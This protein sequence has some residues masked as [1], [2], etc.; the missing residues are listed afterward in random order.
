MNF[1]IDIYSFVLYMIIFGYFGTWVGGFMEY[2]RDNGTHD[3]EAE[4]KKTRRELEQSRELLYDLT[5]HPSV[6]PATR[7]VTRSL[8]VVKG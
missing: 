2:A 4:L 6:R 8:K 1:N 7:A 5:T 3:L